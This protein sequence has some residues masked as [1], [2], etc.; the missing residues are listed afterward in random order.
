MIVSCL[1]CGTM[2]NPQSV[3]HCPACN[4]RKKRYKRNEAD[5]FFYSEVGRKKRLVRSY[6]NLKRSRLENIHK[7]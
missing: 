5:R 3:S 1:Q 7:T 4:F 2:W 6:Q